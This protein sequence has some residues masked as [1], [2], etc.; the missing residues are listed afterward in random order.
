MIIKLTDSSGQTIKGTAV[1]TYQG[2]DISISTIP[3]IPEMR[4]FGGTRHP[5]RDMTESIMGSDLS[6]YP[7]L[8]DLA[9][10]KAQIDF[11][12]GNG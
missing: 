11:Y 9:Y 10:I 12:V 6:M 8:K 2:F 3:T 1:I 5:G 7:T 4:V